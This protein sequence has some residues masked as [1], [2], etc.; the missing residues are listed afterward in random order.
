MR[1]YFA[2][3]R[4]RDKILFQYLFKILQGREN[5]CKKY[6]STIYSKSEIMITIKHK[7]Y[8]IKYSL[9]PFCNYQAMITEKSKGIGKEYVINASLFG[10]VSIAT[11]SSAIEKI[12]SLLDD[13][14]TVEDVCITKEVDDISYTFNN[15]ARRVIIEPILEWAIAYFWAIKVDFAKQPKGNSDICELIH[16]ANLEGNVYG[17]KSI[18]LMEEL[19]SVVIDVLERMHDTLI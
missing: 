5:P 7:K 8:D 16:T 10:N 14:F 9:D 2:F 11:K 1:M 15:D 17:T 19:E 13:G 4:Q 3:F 18:E 6:L 12:Q